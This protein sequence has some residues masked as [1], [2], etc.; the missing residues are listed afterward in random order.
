MITF[1]PNLK[2]NNFQSNQIKPAVRYNYIN[3]VNNQNKT[4]DDFTNNKQSNQISFMGNPLTLIKTENKL[5]KFGGNLIGEEGAKLS[6]KMKR[7]SEE[8][9]ILVK[10][11][12]RKL[13]KQDELP[14]AEKP[15]TCKMETNEK[16]Q[17]ELEKKTQE[18]TDVKFRR[19]DSE[20]AITGNGESVSSGDINSSGYLTTSGKKK[21]GL[22]H[23]DDFNNTDDL[24][25]HDKT[26]F[27][28]NEEGVEKSDIDTRDADLK[29]ADVNLDKDLDTDLDT[30][31][32]RDLDTDLNTDL[33]TDLDLDLDT[34]LDLDLNLDP[35][36]DLDID[37]TDLL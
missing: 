8:S 3:I 7:L 10:R 23:N 11:I 20:K 33:D 2:E 15:I 34:D 25:N 31:L 6:G 30:E 16:M 14:F 36:L 4:T 19:A 24:N 12:F 1:I 35:D 32:D 9:V 37:L 5:S 29:D 17:K 18:W 13:K 26:S 21:A 22:S 28:G 27:R